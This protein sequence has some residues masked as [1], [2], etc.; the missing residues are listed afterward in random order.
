MPNL[1]IG[2]IN[3]LFPKIKKYQPTQISHKLSLLCEE[4]LEAYKQPV[5]EH[6]PFDL[7]TLDIGLTDIAGPAGQ[8]A[9]NKTSVIDLLAWPH[10]LCSARI[11]SILDALIAG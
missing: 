9:E 8:V 4:T 7:I 10:S 11:G 5:L 2:S 6:Q 1:S 3:T